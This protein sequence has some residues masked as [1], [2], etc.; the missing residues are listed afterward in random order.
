M[1]ATLAMLACGAVHAQS[2]ATVDSAESYVTSPAMQRT[3]LGTTPLR[4][5]HRTEGFGQ[6]ASETAIGG[7]GAV[8]LAGAV[9]FVDGQFRISNESRFGTNLGGG[10]RWYGN[11]FLTGAER[12]FGVS[13]WYDGQ[14]T[15]L[16]NYFNQGG[17]SLESLGEFVDLRFNANIPFEDEKTGGQ[18]FITGEL[19]FIGNSLAQAT[20]IPTD[21]A[22]RVVDVEAAVRI[23]DLNAWVYGG[24]Y[25]MDGNGVS[26]GGPKVGARGYI[27]NDLA[28]DVG[29]TDDDT[30]GTNTVFQIIWMPGRTGAG[31]TSWIH[32]LADRMREPVYRNAYVATQ[33]VETRGSIALTGADG[34]ELSIVHVDFT[35]AGGGD[36]TFENP[37]TSLDSVNGGGSDQGDIILVHAQN[38]ANVYNGQAVTLKDEQRLLGEGGGIEH[39]VVTQQRGT[40]VLPETFAGALN[41]TRPTL[42]NAPGAAVTLAGITNESESFSQMEVSNFVITGGANA[43]VSGANGVAAVDINNLNVSG[44]TGD[45]INLAAMTQTLA[46]GTTRSRFAVTIDEITFDNVGNDDADD[47]IELDAGTVQTTISHSTAISNIAS[48]NG[49]G[50]GINLVEMQR[51]V[52]INNYD[53]DGGAN[54]LGAL[55]ITDSA[56]QGAVTLS[57]SE[58]GDDNLF[59]GGTVGGATTG[60]AIKIDGGLAATHTVTGTVITNMGGDAII[61]EGGTS[62]MNFTGRIT[63]TANNASILSV[64]DEHDGSLTFTELVANQG[65][66]NATTGDGL[67]FNNADGNYTF[68]D[69]VDFTGTSAAI[70]VANDSDAVIVVQDGQFTNTTGNTITFVGGEG[71]LTFN[72]KIEQNQNA[73]VLSVTGGHNG[74]LIFNDLAADPGVIEA[75]NGGGLFFEDADGSYTF[76]DL[77]TLNGGDAHIEIREGTDAANGS[78][79]IFVFSDADITNPSTSAAVIIDDSEVT[80]TYTGTITANNADAVQIINNSGGSITF[81]STIDSTQGIL[82]Q[83]NSAGTTILFA[84]EINLTGAGAGLRILENTGANVTFSDTINSAL[85]L[86]VQDNTAGTFAFTGQVS[87][88]GTTDGVNIL[89]NTGGTTSFNNIDITKTGGGDGFT[90]TSAVAGHTVTVT[91][92]DNNISTQT[93]TALNLNTIAAGAA[94]INFESVSS[95]GAV[96][97]IIINNVTGGPV[98]IGMN[99]A[100][101]M[102]GTIQNSTG[103]AVQI[104]NAANVNLNNMQI[105]NTAVGFNSVTVTHNNSVASAVSITN[106]D[107][108]GGL[109]G[110]DL[111]RTA[112]GTTSFALRG[113]TVINTAGDAINMNIGGSGTANIV[114]QNNSQIDGGDDQ[115][116]SVAVT[117]GSAKNV[118]MLVDGNTMSNNS[119]ASTAQIDMNGG[120][121]LNATVSNNTM[122]NG[123]AGAARALSMESTSGIVRLALNDNTGINSGV[124]EEILLDETGGDFRIEDLA[125]V[126]ARNGGP[127]AIEFQPAQIN[128]TN[129]PGPIPT[130]TN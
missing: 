95:N 74:T 60:Y 24:G 1:V 105:Q 16:N 86:L 54:G 90:A 37:Y 119:L 112:T 89:N 79:G 38:G 81:N 130:P 115:A 129:D 113:S 87:L 126:D 92:N 61:A 43:V 125:T 14:E 7:R 82:V 77:V 85:T 5:G 20:L 122:S 107:I 11:D 46:N 25:Q 67:Q 6:E 41:A 59:T 35:N 70:N 80:F 9:G 31:P 100:A 120:G 56:A 101:D 121:T 53:W 106:T 76:N 108:S 65:V 97:G 51:A 66:I 19:D 99:A 44:T 96:N 84:D 71:F 83:D 27:T 28:V 72:G 30:F 49:D 2:V 102:G 116:L 88:T 52:T 45:G 118:L 93:G 98:N 17:V 26:D 36:G 39:E 58:V 117:G 69:A 12:I 128:F 68:N 42:Q 55:L 124:E 109:E 111:N 64:T 32:T 3:S 50:N 91:G 15:V 22:L 48:T 10:V 73:L 23:Y 18:S 104:T 110:I 29:V 94:G 13:G 40:I 57:N 123:N 21:V 47:D 34:Q 33:Q 4:L 63:Q 8:D 127:G 114:V 75:T 103:A 62:N 78:E